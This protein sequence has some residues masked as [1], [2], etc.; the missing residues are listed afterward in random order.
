MSVRRSQRLLDPLFT[1][2]KM[3][4]IFSD[5]GRLQG[6]TPVHEA[7]R[8]RPLAVLGLDA[9]AGEDDSAVPGGDGTG[10]HP[11]VQVQGEPAGESGVLLIG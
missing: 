8:Q 7:P 2:E 11:R 9:A 6:L 3:R 4:G 10:G 5:R 1:T